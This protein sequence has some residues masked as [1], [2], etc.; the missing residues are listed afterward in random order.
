MGRGHAS[1][2]NKVVDTLEP[3]S[4]L[5]NER[6]HV[7]SLRRDG[8]VLK[9]FADKVLVAFD[10]DRTLAVVGATDLRHLRDG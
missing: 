2:R 6:V 9:P 10:R 5:P 8:R 7:V 3:A 1:K 4:L